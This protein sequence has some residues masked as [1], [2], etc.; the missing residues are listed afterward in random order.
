MTKKV[1]VK[2]VAAETK[3]ESTGFTLVNFET[4]QFEHYE[5]Y[6]ELVKD[7]E[8]MLASDLING[9]GQA[10]LDENILVFK[11]ICRPLVVNARMKVEV[12]EGKE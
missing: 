9:T 6:D 1:A 2:K 11:G 4:S 3:D 10:W 12:I 7:L 8:D 5:T